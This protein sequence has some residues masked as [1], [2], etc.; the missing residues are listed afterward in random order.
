MAQDRWIEIAEVARIVRRDLG[1]TIQILR[2]AGSASAASDIPSVRIEECIADLGLDV[3]IAGL[4][5]R[6]SNSG[7]VSSLWAHCREIAE[8]AA[9]IAEETPEADPA[10]GYLVGL[11]HAIYAIPPLLG[12]TAAADGECDYALVGLALAEMWSLPSCIRDLFSARA[13]ASNADP[14]RCMLSEAHRRAGASFRSGHCSG[15]E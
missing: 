6:G 13:G 15:Y 2:M 7:C 5:C 14:W 12:W 10:E 4:S 1:A 9:L 11:L 8:Q 3:C